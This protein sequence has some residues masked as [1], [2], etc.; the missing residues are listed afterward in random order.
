MNTTFSIII[1]DDHAMFLDGLISILSTEAN[2]NIALTAKSGL[3]VLKYLRINTQNYFSPRIKQILM[4][5]MFSE[6]SKPEIALSKRE[7]YAVEKGLLN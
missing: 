5:A 7:R 2:I 4:E 6:K 3:Q 1:V